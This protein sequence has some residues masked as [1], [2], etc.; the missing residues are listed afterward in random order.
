MGVKWKRGWRWLQRWISAMRWD[1]ILSAITWP[2]TTS[3]QVRGGFSS[4]VHKPVAAGHAG[5]LGRLRT[6]LARRASRSSSPSTIM[7]V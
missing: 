3:L 2:E 1:G 4:S 7:A 6:A 5:H